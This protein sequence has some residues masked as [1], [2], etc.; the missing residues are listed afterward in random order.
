MD[1]QFLKN[2]AVYIVSAIISLLLIAYILYHLFGDFDSEIE[3][4]AAETVTGRELVTLDGYI[5]RSEQVL[6]SSSQGDLNYMYDDG[7]R[8]KNGAALANVYASGGSSVRSQ[9][10]E[11]DR[12]LNLLEASSF[13]ES[14]TVSDTITIDAQIA[15]LYSVIHERVASGDLE[16]ALRKKDE[17]LVLLNKRRI[18]VQNVENYDDK[19][20]ALT[21][22]RNG[23]TAQLT[24]I[25]E[26][27][28]APTPGYFYS[29]LDGYE[30]IFDSSKLDDLTLDKF[31]EMTEAEP[32]TSYSGGYGVGKLV[33]D[34]YWY[35]ACPV[36]T[37]QLRYFTQGSKYSVIFPYSSDVELKMTLSKIVEQ[38]DENRAVLVFGTGMMPEN[39][40]FLR[41]QTIDI[42]RDTYTGYRV[43]VAAVRI[44]DGE[45][46]VY[47]LNGNFVRFKL[48]EPLFESEGY[49][50]VSEYQ[51]VGE[52]KRAAALEDDGGGYLALNDLII[53]KGKKLY[54]GRIIS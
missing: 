50:I 16:Y 21:S 3:T 23:L 49:F 35:I 36:S 25:T 34:Y 33:S 31:F 11:L 46:G 20:T 12:K 54:D 53:T 29:G 27:V 52:D 2:V 41:K 8:V 22:Q 44:V 38:T 10:I 14:I 39:F 37:D 1:T 48:I 9:I 42:V 5:M 6:F 47:A 24:N 30:S 32:V 43:P 4:V 19:I 17:L 15:E 18:I 45:Q 51:N 40:N 13:G 7:T 28:Y 26:T